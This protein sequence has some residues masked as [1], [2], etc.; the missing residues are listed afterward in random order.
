MSF[1]P[2]GTGTNPM[3]SLIKSS[4]TSNVINLISKAIPPLVLQFRQLQEFIPVPVGADPR[5]GASQRSS[6]IFQ[7]QSPLPKVAPVATV[8]RFVSVPPPMQHFPGQFGH[9]ARR[10]RPPLHHHPH[11]CL[12]NSNNP[13][14]GV[15]RE[16]R[17]MLKPKNK[18]PCLKIPN[19]V[20]ERCS[21]YNFSGKGCPFGPDCLRLH[22]C[23]NCGDPAHR[24]P[25]CP[26][27]Q[28]Y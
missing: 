28:Q 16:K 2:N 1:T 10:F 18:Q 13:G 5:A 6:P 24:S 3:L 22:V 7:Y 12:I 21:A 14:Q 23:F 20:N 19:I 15:K 27:P 11:P 9:P 4:R 26:H 25:Q 17:P 8:Q